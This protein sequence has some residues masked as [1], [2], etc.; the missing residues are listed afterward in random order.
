M[1]HG[2]N[3]NVVFHDWGLKSF[4]IL[5]SIGVTG[6]FL[7]YPNLEHGPNDQMIADFS[8]YIQKVLAPRAPSKL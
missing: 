7:S 5:K 1:C 6:N 3:D 8:S 2:E 4:Q